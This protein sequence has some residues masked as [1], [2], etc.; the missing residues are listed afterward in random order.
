MNHRE[1]WYKYVQP[2]QRGDRER[3]D[4]SSI[5]QR[6]KLV[7]LVAKYERDGL[8]S[9]NTTQ[10]DCDCAKWTSGGVMAAVPIAVEK[11]VQ[12]LYDNAEGTC[13][14]WLDTP[15]NVAEYASRD[16]A[17]EAFEDGHPHVVYA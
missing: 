13:S 5:A 11:A 8:V 6:A 7:A 2:N 3:E 4:Q 10:M 9:F 15:K 14:W 1:V 12:D 17:L 16:L